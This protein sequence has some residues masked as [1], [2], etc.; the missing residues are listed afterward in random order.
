MPNMCI[1][2]GVDSCW[3]QWADTIVSCCFF[4]LGFMVRG[5][6]INLDT[7]IPMQPQTEHCHIDILIGI[8]NLMYL[9]SR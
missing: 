6:E 3:I 1:G 4:K 9:E 8:G 5:L 2:L 7:L